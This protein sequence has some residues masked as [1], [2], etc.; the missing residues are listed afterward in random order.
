MQGVE[1][2]HEELVCVVLV[3]S[4]KGGRGPR[5]KSLEHSGRDG[6]GGGVGLSTEE[7]GR[8]EGQGGAG[9]GAVPVSHGEG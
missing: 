5:E 1:Q 2:S 8:L 4:V 9:G 6:G 3:A 7:G